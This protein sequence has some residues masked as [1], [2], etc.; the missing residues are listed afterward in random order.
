[1]KKLKL[2]I[3]LL[4][5]LMVLPGCQKENTFE[6]RVNLKEQVILDNQVAETRNPHPR[7]F[8]ASFTSTVV[9]TLPNPVVCGEDFPG[10]NLIQSLSGN[11]TH[12][13]NISGSIS[14]CVIPFVIIFNGEVTLVAANGDKLFFEQTGP[15]ALEIYDGTGRFA[16]A[17]GSVTSSFEII[18]PGSVFASE[19]D[20]EIYY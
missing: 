12:M 14:S 13:G 2:F 4:V 11:A 3:P 7:P 8:H 5:I 1:M 6:D 16:G 20:G 9:S 15:G 19:F 17:T 10:F 18:V